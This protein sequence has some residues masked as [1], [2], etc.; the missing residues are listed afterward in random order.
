MEFIRL[1]NG[2][3]IRADS[4]LAVLTAEARA[5]DSLCAEIKPRVIVHNQ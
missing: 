5:A 4:I 3:C 2:G 1:N